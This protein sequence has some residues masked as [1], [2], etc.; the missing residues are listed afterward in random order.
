MPHFKQAGNLGGGGIHSAARGKA[1][2][3]SE[4]DCKHHSLTFSCFIASGIREYAFG[5][6]L[7]A[8]RN[9]ENLHWTKKRLRV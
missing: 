6:F 8:K 3:T 1:D 2:R 7:M 4:A 5:T 9:S